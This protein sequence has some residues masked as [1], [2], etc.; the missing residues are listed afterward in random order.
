VADD[1]NIKVGVDP[2]GAKEGADEFKAATD[3]VNEGA[4]HAQEG[5]ESLHESFRGLIGEEIKESLEGIEGALGSLNKILIG[6]GVG[7]VVVELRE[8]VEQAK[9]MEESSWPRCPSRM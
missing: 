5:V 2:E 7:A 4:K 3:K 9:E 6:L 8:L 1:Y